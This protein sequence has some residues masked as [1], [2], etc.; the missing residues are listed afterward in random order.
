MT[1]REKAKV[2]LAAIA[3]IV[4]E[5]LEEAR[6]TALGGIPAGHLYAMLMGVMSLSTFQA[7]MNGLVVSGKVTKDGLVY[8][9]GDAICGRRK[10]G[11]NPRAMGTNPRA[12]GT[13][14]RADG[15]R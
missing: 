11:T 1:D 14:P 2:A 7:I 6:H 15:D 9:V 4:V 13:N 5:T 8:R 10:D 3:D 12:V